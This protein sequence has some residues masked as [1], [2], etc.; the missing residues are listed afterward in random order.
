MIGRWLDQLSARAGDAVLT[1][2]MVPYHLNGPHGRCLVGVAGGFER[3]FKALGNLQS[4]A[5]EWKRVIPAWHGKPQM[6]ALGYDPRLGDGIGAAYNDLCERLG[7]VRANDLVR[8][9][10]LRRRVRHTLGGAHA[11]R[12]AR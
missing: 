6:H 11:R 5:S 12:V 10:V 8:A 7:V 9:R 4:A 2:P 3:K 1:E